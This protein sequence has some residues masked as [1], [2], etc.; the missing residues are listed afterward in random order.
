MGE[1]MTPAMQMALKKALVAAAA[2]GLT[3]F[4]REY[5]IVQGRIDREAAGRPLGAAAK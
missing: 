2:A 1:G 5:T 3:V 4:F